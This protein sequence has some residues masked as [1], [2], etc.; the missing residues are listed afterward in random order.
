MRPSRCLPW[1]VVL[2]TSPSRTEAMETTPGQVAPMKPG[3]FR[4]LAGRTLTISIS[5]ATLARYGLLLCG[6]ALILAGYV[7]IGWSDATA[8]D[9]RGE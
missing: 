2:N 1:R 5:Y 6:Y 8:P 7:L 4:K 3:Q 9:S